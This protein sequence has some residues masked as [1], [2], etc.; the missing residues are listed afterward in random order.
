MCN[1]I[2]KSIER[3]PS[4]S[5][6]WLGDNSIGDKGAIET[7]QALKH[8]PP[9][10][11]FIWI[12]LVI[13]LLTK[14]RQ[15]LQALKYV[16]SLS[17]LGLGDNSIG[18]KGA[19]E[20]AQALKDVPSLSELNLS[21]NSI[22]DKGAIEIAQALKHVP[23]LSELHLD[24]NSIGDKGAIELSQALKHVPSSLNFIWVIIP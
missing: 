23:S 14:V 1:R 12:M 18:D 4:L 19:T 7:A 17:V 13:P 8:V 2:I 24:Y 10:L 21:L 6:L 9:S 5:Q 11:Y 15:K 22:G 3:R 20:L 16:P